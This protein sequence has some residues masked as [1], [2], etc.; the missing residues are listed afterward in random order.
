MN[1]ITSIEVR[2]R[3]APMIDTLQQNKKEGSIREKANYQ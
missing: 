1:S 2:W 3:I